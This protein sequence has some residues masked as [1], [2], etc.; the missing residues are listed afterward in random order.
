[1]NQKLAPSILYILTNTDGSF[2][3]M[4]RRVI[5]ARSLPKAPEKK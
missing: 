1:M 5:E 3:D 4:L 2:A